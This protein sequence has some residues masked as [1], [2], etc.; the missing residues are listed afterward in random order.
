MRGRR[1]ASSVTQAPGEITYLAVINGNDLWVA[2]DVPA[3]PGAELV[4]IRRKHRDIRPLPAPTQADLTGQQVR[5]SALLAAGS[6][7]ALLRAGDEGNWDLAV[8]APGRSPVRLRLGEHAQLYPTPPASPVAGD[9]GM[10][11]APYRTANGL[12]ALRVTAAPTSIEVTGVV[13]EP[14]R[15]ALTLELVRWSGPEPTTL[16]LA[17]RGGAGHVSVPLA[18]TDG[19]AAVIVPLDQVAQE[20]PTP[21]SSVWDVSVQSPGG[22]TRCGRTA[23]DVSDPRRVYRYVTSSYQPPAPGPV[24]MFRPYFTKDRYLAVEIDVTQQAASRG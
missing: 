19:V 7:V 16:I 8:R 17:Q 3:W 23:R 10:V 11:V 18:M 15:L 20:A 14:G 24:L 6:L 21:S 4:A 5:P 22:V 12:A 1:F 2:A 13:S 9:G